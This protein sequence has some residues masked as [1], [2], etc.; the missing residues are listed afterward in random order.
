MPLMTGFVL[1]LHTHTPLTFLKLLQHGVQ[2]GVVEHKVH[3]MVVELGDGL[4]R[5]AII[6]I[7]EGE[8]FDEEDIHDVAQLVL[9]DG[10][11]R[12]PALHDLRH[13][14]KIQHRV[15]VDHEAVA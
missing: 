8:V 14:V 7:H 15:A 6:R 2:L 10:N 3:W 11:P 9:V 1:L 5:R 12:V 4:Q 13:G